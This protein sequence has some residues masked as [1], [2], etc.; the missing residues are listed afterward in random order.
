MS[1]TIP[2]TI[3]MTLGNVVRIAVAVTT[4]GVPVDAGL[5]QI[6]FKAPDGTIIPV[7]PLTH[8]GAA[9]SGTYH[10]DYQPAMFGTYLYRVITSA[11]NAEIDGKVIVLPT[12][13]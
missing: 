10:D 8:D 11:P 6:T 4:L 5:A 7:A 9:G 13:F 2:G 1:I 12:A 3:V